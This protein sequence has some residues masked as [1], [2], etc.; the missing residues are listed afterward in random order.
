MSRK[1]VITCD[2]CGNVIPDVRYNGSYEVTRDV[3]R[4]WVMGEREE[5][6]V[7]W[8]LCSTSC[9]MVWADAGMVTA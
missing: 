2:Q 8:T 9:L 1:V 7:E 4:V 3:P 5:R 6:P